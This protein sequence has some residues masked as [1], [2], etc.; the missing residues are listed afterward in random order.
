MIIDPILGKLTD[1]YGNLY[2][3]VRLWQGEIQTDIFTQPLKVQFVGTDALGLT[4]PLQQLLSLFL[5]Q[6]KDYKKL[7]LEALFSYYQTEILPLWR[8]NDYFGVPELA[9]QLVPNVQDIFEFEKLLSDPRLI[10][11]NPNCW[12]F[13]FE[14]TWD[15]EHGVG[16]LFRDGQVVATGFA[17]IAH[18]ALF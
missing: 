9:S 7:L 16:I 8:A 17:E 18:D 1:C 14:C 6:A 15:V 12:G 13:E 4:L 2:A 10:L 5:E 3:P 11:N